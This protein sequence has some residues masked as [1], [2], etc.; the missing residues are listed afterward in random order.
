MRS[1]HDLDDLRR[2]L[3]RLADDAPAF[4]PRTV[5]EPAEQAS[6]LG[7]RSRR[8]RRSWIL[9]AAAAGLLVALV[10]PWAA[11][12]GGADPVGAPAQQA[13]GDA[14]TTATRDPGPIPVE[15][16]LP[17]HGGT[18]MEA[19]LDGPTVVMAPGCVA[20]VGPND[21]L[22]PVIWP[23]G[24]SSETTEEGTYLVRP[25]GTRVVRLGTPDRPGPPLR[26]GG[27]YGAAV[28]SAC[29]GAGITATEGFWAGDVELG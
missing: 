2:D 1:E 26:I 22:V 10:L 28:P 18:G 16:R 21:D 15:E 3:R 14:T 20:V 19:L 17:A 24:Y 4:D 5:R 12:L 13:A 27:G 9:G 11:M 23:Q 7:T 8:P 6:E 25:D 29:R